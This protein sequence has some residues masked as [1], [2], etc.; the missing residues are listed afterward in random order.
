MENESLKNMAIKELLLHLADDDFIHAY[1]GSEWLGL[2]PHIE[3]DVASSSIAQD[4]MG[5]AAIFYQLLEEIGRER[6]IGSPTTVPPMN[7]AM[8]SFS[9]LPMVPDI[10]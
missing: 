8:P 9:K 4:T 5:H 7:G 1:R 10:I 3:E 2:A 6:Q